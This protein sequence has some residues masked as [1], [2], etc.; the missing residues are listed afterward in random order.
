MRAVKWMADGTHVDGG[1]DG[2]PYSIVDRVLVPE[3]LEEGDYLLSWRC[4]PLRSAAAA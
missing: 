4:T 1:D 3:G 2:F